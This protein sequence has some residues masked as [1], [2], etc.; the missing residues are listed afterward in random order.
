[1]FLEGVCPKI[2]IVCACVVIV[3]GASLKLSF[4]L[5]G[6]RLQ[7]RD[8]AIGVLQLALEPLDH[9]VQ[10]VEPPRC[11]APLTG[12]ALHPVG[13]AT[14]RPVAP[15]QVL[16]GPGEVLLVGL[17]L[18]VGTSPEP[19]RGSNFLRTRGR[20]EDLPATG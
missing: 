11:S 18:P 15:P 5:L 19:S 6:L 8:A 10:G 4:P 20:Q 2:V 16:P 14:A 3:V 12:G 13:L 1:M 9:V 7:L 17:G